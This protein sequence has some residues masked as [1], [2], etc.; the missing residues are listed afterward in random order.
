MRQAT[1]LLF[2]V[3]ALGATASTTPAQEATSSKDAPRKCLAVMGQVNAPGRFELRRRVRLLEVLA[4]AGGFTD[5]AGDMIQVTSTG[6]DCIRSAGDATIPAPIM[7]AENRPSAA[8]SVRSFLIKDINTEDEAKNPY[9]QPG[10]IVVVP[11]VEQA[12][13]IGHVVHPRAVA[14]KKSIT[15]TGALMMAGGLTKTAKRDDVRIIRRSA[16]DP[17][18]EIRVDLDKI[19]K[20]RQPDPVLQPNDIID[21]GPR[22]GLSGPLI[23]LTIKSPPE[24][25]IRVIY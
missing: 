13:V 8:V 4:F 7:S 17:P 16:S 19:R 24:P 6:A 22:H 3:I 18:I 5:R 15:L 21:V 23:G 20:K 11:E 14:L 25:P 1:L 9:L 10:D 12:F 2:V